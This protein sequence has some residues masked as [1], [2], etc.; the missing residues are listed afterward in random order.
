MPI[1]VIRHVTTYHYRRPVA[2]GEH[3][4]MLRPR[5]DEI[6]RHLTALTSTRVSCCQH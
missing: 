1:F 2:F 4:M 6:A 5:D 3:R